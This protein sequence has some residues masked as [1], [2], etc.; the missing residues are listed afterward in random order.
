MTMSN[1]VDDGP[2]LREDRADQFGDAYQ[3]P[4]DG[5]SED[6]YRYRRGERPAY[7]RVTRP[8]TP[9]DYPEPRG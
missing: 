6:D 1:A 8:A 5:L 7:P 3:P 4:R 9:F 2:R